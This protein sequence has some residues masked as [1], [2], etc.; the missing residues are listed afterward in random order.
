MNPICRILIACLFFCTSLNLIG[1]TVVP[2]VSLDTIVQSQDTLDW[3]LV[4]YTPHN[5]QAHFTLTK[6]DSTN[7][8]R[9]LSVA[10]AFT[11]AGLKDV[12]GDFVVDGVLKENARDKETGFCLMY[13]DTII[14]DSLVDSG[15]M[16]KNKAIREHGCYFQQMLLLKGGDTVECTIFRKQKPTFRR[17]LAIIH[18]RGVVIE[19]VSRMTFEDFANA[20][21]R[22]GV[23]D[24]IYLDMGTW[25]EGFIR[26]Q[27]RSIET[28]GHLRQNT[29]YQTNWIEYVYKAPEILSK[30][31]KQPTN[32]RQVK[33]KANGKVSQVKINR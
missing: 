30:R 33:K 13:G 6:P 23:K 28:I 11:A 16:A 4:L 8:T 19:S 15:L 22:I 18:N 5:C 1:Q 9:A 3:S 27:D 29:K 17:C 26:H 32:I 31:I 21:K 7:N 12:V 2:Y 20:V 25:S 14:I 24:A 10:G